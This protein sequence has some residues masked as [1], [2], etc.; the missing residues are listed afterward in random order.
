MKLRLQKMIPDF[1]VRSFQIFFLNM[2]IVIGRGHREG[3]PAGFSKKLKT[4]F[5]LEILKNPFNRLLLEVQ[6]LTRF[7]LFRISQQ[8]RLLEASKI[9]AE[10]GHGRQAY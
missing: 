5:F 3:G 7:F 4:P 6:N 9:S 1:F 10:M 2:I 8:I